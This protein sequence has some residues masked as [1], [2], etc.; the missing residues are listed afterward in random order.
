VAPASVLSPPIGVPRRVSMTLRCACSTKRSVRPAQHLWF[1]SSSEAI[2]HL[3][4]ARPVG[5]WSPSCALATHPRIAQRARD[6]GFGVVHESR[7][8]LE[9]VIACIQSIPS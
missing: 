5:P 2:D 6:C 8:T 9:A 7:P 3:A 4:Q 1:F